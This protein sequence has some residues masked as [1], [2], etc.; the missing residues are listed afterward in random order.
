MGAHSNTEYNYQK[1]QEILAG[2]GSTWAAPTTKYTSDQICKSGYK[3]KP[4]KIP[5]CENN[6]WPTDADYKCYAA[7]CSLD[8]FYEKQLDHA[9]QDKASQGVAGLKRDTVLSEYFKWKP[10]LQL[11]EKTAISHP[12]FNPGKICQDN[13]TFPTTTMPTCNTNDGWNDVKYW[14]CVSP[15]SENKVTTKCPQIKI[16][17]GAKVPSTTLNNVIQMNNYCPTN[18]TPSPS[19][20]QCV[21]NGTWST[22]TPTCISDAS[23]PTC[24]LDQFYE[25]Q[26]KI[27]NIDEKKNKNEILE[28]L[29]WKGWT[30]LPSGDGVA[31]QQ[32]AFKDSEICKSGFN[33]S[34]KFDPPLCKNGIWNWNAHN[35]HACVPSD[36]PVATVDTDAGSSNEG[37]APDKPT[38]DFLAGDGGS[39]QLCVQLP[40]PSCHA[41]L[42]KKFWHSLSKTTC[43]DTDKINF[44]KINKK[45]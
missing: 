12:S 38:C 27:N 10:W 35:S 9:S 21:G 6:A 19:T 25:I 7:T 16:T 23:E 20:I 42:K 24:T 3:F 31:V 36:A 18:S 44:C 43:T 40:I 32:L 45:K 34:K 15:K 5:T 8:T 33:F 14:P 28:K 2:M 41:C 11:P 17:G 4:D 26:V 13:Y 29:N 30:A 1:W 37:A 22:P 39:A